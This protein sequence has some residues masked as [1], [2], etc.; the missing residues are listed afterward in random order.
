MLNVEPSYSC[1]LTSWL[2]SL[3][4][5]FL[6]IPERLRGNEKRFGSPCLNL[7]PDRS[8]KMQSYV[9]LLKHLKCCNLLQSEAISHAV[10]LNTSRT[11]H[12]PLRPRSSESLTTSDTGAIEF[13]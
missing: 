10:Q 9:R 5:R 11:P 7:T 1:S 3:G 8:M 6:D 4:Y 13:G 12:L 2:I